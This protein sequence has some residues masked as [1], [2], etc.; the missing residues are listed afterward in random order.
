MRRKLKVNLSV[1]LVST[2]LLVVRS[3]PVTSILTVV[4]GFAAS[5]MLMK[6]TILPAV[7]PCSKKF[8]KMERNVGRWVL[9]R[10]WLPLNNTHLQ[11]PQKRQSQDYSSGQGVVSQFILSHIVDQGAQRLS[12][13]SQIPRS[14]CQ[15]YLPF[16][17]SSARVHGV[18]F[19]QWMWL[20]SPN[21]SHSWTSNIPSTEPRIRLLCCRYGENFFSR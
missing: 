16:R 21:L 10:R 17:N 6:S 4:L 15:I 3:Y 19:L 14:F 20:T 11:R 13:L 12:F 9:L 2:A 8:H 1:I 7:A 18:Q 5:P